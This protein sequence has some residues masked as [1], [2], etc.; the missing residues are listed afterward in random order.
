MSIS[1]AQAHP[2]YP[3][4]TAK[5]KLFFDHYVLTQDLW[6]SLHVTGAK[7]HTTHIYRQNQARRYLSHPHIQILLGIALNYKVPDHILTRN[8]TLGIISTCIKECGIKEK[9]KYLQLY[10]E[11]R[12]W[13]EKTKSGNNVT[14]IVKKIEAERKQSKE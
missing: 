7:E 6:A 11:I 3:Q 5:Q 14:D 12:G 13:I 4:L 9:H 10:A 2:L 8:E 1:N